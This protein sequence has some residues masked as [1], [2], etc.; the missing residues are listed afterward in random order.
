MQSGGMPRLIAADK[1]RTRHSRVAGLRCSPGNT[2]HVATPARNSSKPRQDTARGEVGHA[3]V[4]TGAT[5]HARI[6]QHDYGVSQRWQTH[7]V[8]A[9]VHHSRSSAAVAFALLESRVHWLRDARERRCIGFE[10]SR[11]AWWAERTIESTARGRIRALG[12]G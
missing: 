12:K 3:V 5:L 11:C 10:C 2:K 9:P 6:G 7:L 8:Q 1:V 4:R